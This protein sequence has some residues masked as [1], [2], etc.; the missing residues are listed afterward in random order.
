MN[1]VSLGTPAATCTTDLIGEASMDMKY[2]AS[3][4]RFVMVRLESAL[5]LSCLA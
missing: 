2:D 1:W 4:S 3:Q 5:L